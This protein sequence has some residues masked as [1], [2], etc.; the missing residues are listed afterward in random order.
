MPR[1]RS[2]RI[3]SRDWLAKAPLKAGDKVGLYLHLD[4]CTVTLLGV[5]ISCLARV[6]IDYGMLS[7]L[8][9]PRAKENDRDAAQSHERE[10]PVRD[11]GADEEIRRL[12]EAQDQG[13][14]ERSCQVDEDGTT[15]TDEFRRVVAH[16]RG[17][18][19]EVVGVPRLRGCLCE[20]TRGADV[21]KTPIGAVVPDTSVAV[22]LVGLFGI[23]GG[24]RDKDESVSASDSFHDNMLAESQ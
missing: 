1:G 5:R 14:L 22:D 17:P 23:S 15:D 7:A 6:S 21:S 12:F 13:R 18:R 9:T 24:Q 3:A 20:C 2:R 11:Q 16:I 4:F 19:P 10:V 8:R